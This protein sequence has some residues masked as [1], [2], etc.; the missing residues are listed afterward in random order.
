MRIEKVH[1]IQRM[2]AESMY[3]VPWTGTST[4]N[5]FRP[6]V[7]NIR[8]SRGYGYGAETLPHIWLDR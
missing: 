8:M 6:W 5:I 1:D 7:K 4:A 2:M 3:F